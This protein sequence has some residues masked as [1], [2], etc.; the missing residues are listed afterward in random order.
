MNIIFKDFNIYQQCLFEAL[1]K[2]NIHIV[3]WLSI[4]N[5]NWF[6]GHYH[7]II[8]ELDLDVIKLWYSL[9]QNKLKIDYIQKYIELQIKNKYFEGK[10]KKILEWLFNDILFTESK[11]NDISD[12][13]KNNIVDTIFGELVKDFRNIFNSSNFILEQDKLYEKFRNDTNGIFSCSYMYHMAMYAR[14]YNRM[15]KVS[16]YCASLLETSIVKSL[17]LINPVNIGVAF[18]KVCFQQHLSRDEEF[19]FHFVM[20][21]YKTCNLTVDIFNIN[22]YYFDGKNNCKNKMSFLINESLSKMYERNYKDENVYDKDGDYAYSKEKT[23]ID[24]SANYYILF[25]RWLCDINFT[26]KLDN[27]VGTNHWE[28][29]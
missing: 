7:H 29:I 5:E 28:N 21:I 20:W 9:I 14:E 12:I 4:V 13:S 8:I 22:V 25:E 1:H 10:N 6:N 18:F 16:K 27:Y 15:R 2:K 24:Y 26:D 19:N 3:K 23:L 17:I 11:D